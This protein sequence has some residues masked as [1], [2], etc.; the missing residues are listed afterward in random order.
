MGGWVGE[1]NKYLD[2][3]TSNCEQHAAETKQNDDCWGKTPMVR[4]EAV[5]DIQLCTCSVRNI[6]NCALLPPSLLG[7]HH[8]S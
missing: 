2:L 6:L 8:E 7:K 4:A 1:Q 5:G 3:G